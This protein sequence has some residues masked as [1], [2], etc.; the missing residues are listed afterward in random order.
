ME[1]IQKHLGLFLDPKLNFFDHVKKKNKNDTK[2]VSVMRKMNLL[3]PHF[4]L[5]P[6]Q[7]FFRPHFNYG[8]VIY[9]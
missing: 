6:I 8:D 9:D 4:S 1:N 2:R 3:L 5:L 7:S